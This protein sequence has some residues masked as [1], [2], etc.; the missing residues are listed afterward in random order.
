M[1]KLFPVLIAVVLTA[2]FTFSIT[3]TAFVLSDSESVGLPGKISEIKSLIDQ[4]AVFSFSE[5]EAEKGAVSGYLS[6]LDD[7]YT[8]FWTKEEYEAQL[9]LNQGNQSGIGISITASDPISDGL[10]VYRVIGNS[11][12]QA[13]GFQ[14]G[15]MITAING[16]SVLGRDYDEVF[17]S[18]KG[19]AGESRT[20][21]YSRDG[22]AYT[23]TVTFADYVQHYVESRMI[24]EIGFIRIHSFMEPTVA[25]FETALN[26]LL[27]QGAKGFIFDLR[28]NLGGSLDAVV[29]ILDY[30]IP[31]GEETVVIKNKDSEEIYYS[32]LDPKTSA[33][34]VV[35]IN[36]SS[37][38]GSELMAS[39]LRDV[40]G[41]QLIG[42]RSY[43]KGIGQTTFYLS[44][45]SA[46][47][48][49]T[50]YYLTKARNDYHGTGLEPDLTVSLDETQEQYFYALTETDDPQL[51]AAL[52]S[53]KK[54]LTGN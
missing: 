41:S 27:E 2:A 37:A 5:E 42:T 35:L 52:D 14:A 26:A 32:E 20:L 21:T 39:C 43:G 15:D 53:L 29:K 34:M 4:Y 9:S 38:S 25:E 19:N 30:L 48:M 18:L 13:A 47:K 24:G 51:Q 33:P 23:A 12:A 6:G 45:Q 54:Q 49:T 10:F 50:F 1:K 46:V 16:E 7:S 44:D 11:P 22:T 8:Q 3:A 40:N 36:R 17:D 28:N 31:K